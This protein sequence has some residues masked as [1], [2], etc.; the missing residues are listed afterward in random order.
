MNVTDCVGKEVIL[1][2]KHHPLPIR[3]RIQC[4]TK[5][6]LCAQIWGFSSGTFWEEVK[7]I[8][9]LDEVVK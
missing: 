6:G 3:A 7:D 4:L 9:V 8:N 2:C 1:T 5:A